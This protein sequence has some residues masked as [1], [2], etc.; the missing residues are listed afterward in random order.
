MRIHLHSTVYVLQAKKN[1]SIAGS[2]T[3][4]DR[5]KE[6]AGLSEETN[7]CYPIYIRIRTYD[8]ANVHHNNKK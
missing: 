1:P 5:P 3:Y 7:T 2:R 4:I 6:A 8:D